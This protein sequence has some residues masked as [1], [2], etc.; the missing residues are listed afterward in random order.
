MIHVY[1]VCKEVA[2]SKLAAICRAGSAVVS[3]E[4]DAGSSLEKDEHAVILAR[5]YKILQIM[6]TSQMLL[7]VP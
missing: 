6:N 3:L 4:V 5:G 7:A 2:R 1:E